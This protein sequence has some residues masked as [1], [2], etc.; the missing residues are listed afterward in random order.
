[1]I[2]PH[3][4]DHIKEDAAYFRMGL[5]GLWTYNLFIRGKTPALISVSEP[6][7]PPIKA[8]YS[9]GF[10]GPLGQSTASAK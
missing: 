7:I 5:S 6:A 8:N 9:I 3:L 10:G 1:M 2:K 4:W